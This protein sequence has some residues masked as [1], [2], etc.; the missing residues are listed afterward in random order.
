MSLEA[1]AADPSGLLG[2]SAYSTDCFAGQSR[3]GRASDFDFCVAFD[4]AALTYGLDLPGADYLPQLPRFEAK[5][6][7]RRHAAAGKLL[8]NDEGLIEARIA[9]V[10][11]LTSQRLRSLN[12]VS[13]VSEQPV[14]V[15]RAA[16]AHRPIRTARR[17]H[18]R[19][20]RGRNPRP[21]AD[22]DFLE[23]EGYIY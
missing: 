15:A 9:Q 18:V 23:R 2:L 16:R 3:S 20:P 12:P 1:S 5:E 6:I 19:R 13:V 22:P 21:K 17:Q 14:A 8:S 11:I 4:K 7:A 10:G